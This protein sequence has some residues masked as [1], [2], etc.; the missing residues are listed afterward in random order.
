MAFLEAKGLWK[1]FGDSVV[2]E[3]V[4]LSVKQG[5]FI[6]IVGTLRL[7]QDHLPAYVA[8]CRTAFTR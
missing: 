1:T 4:N 7:W 6:T 2:L 3:N 5:E 8:G